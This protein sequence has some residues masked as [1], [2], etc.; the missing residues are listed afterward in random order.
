MCLCSLVCMYFG[1]LQTTENVIC[2]HC[3]VSVS[4][5]GHV[6]MIFCFPYHQWRIMVELIN[7][8]QV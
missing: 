5:S 3:G 2:M 4:S 6:S 1:L 7:V 8:K